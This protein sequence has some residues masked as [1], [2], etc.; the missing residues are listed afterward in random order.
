MADRQT[1]TLKPEIEDEVYMKFQH[2]PHIYF[3]EQYSGTN[4]STGRRQGEWEIK[5]G[6]L[7]PEADMK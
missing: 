4:F 7:E 6:R 3:I 2:N 1:E 5:D